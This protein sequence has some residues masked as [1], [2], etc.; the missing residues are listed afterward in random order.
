MKKIL[1]IAAAAT[2]LMTSCQKTDVLNVAEDTIDF[3]TQVGKLTKAN[4]EYDPLGTLKGQGFRVWTVAHFTQGQWKDGQIYRGMENLYVRYDSDYTTNPWIINSN[5][6]YFWPQ[7]QQYLQF[8]TISSNVMKPNSTDEYWVDDVRYSDH[9]TKPDGATEITG[10]DLPEYTVNDVADDDVMVADV[11]R[12]TKDDGSGN[13]TKTVSP[14]FRHTMTKV[15]FKFKKGTP[16]QNAAP[17]A[18]TVILKEIKTSALSYKGSLD[19]TYGAG[20]TEMSFEWTPSTGEGTTKV[21]SYT[22]STVVYL[23][24]KGKEIPVVDD[25][26]TEELAENQYCKIGD[27][28]YAYTKETEDATQLT[29]NVTTDY[30]TYNGDVLSADDFESYVTW[31]MIPQDLDE[32]QTVEITYIADGK[33]IP[34]IFKLTVNHSTDLTKD[35]TEEM[36]V[37]YNVT[38]TPQKVFFN[39]EVKPWDTD[40]DDDGTDDTDVDMEN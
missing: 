31:Y 28:V 17:V 4:D 35:W 21:F 9:F 6:R 32:E 15:E 27:T 26:P 37:K 3:S 20:T 34:Q 19:V 38:I 29:W 25:Y 11:K 14:Y 5:E 7:A 18:S 12:Q 8:Y 13:K 22:P 40:Q 36:W 30:E 39:P 24:P 23:D 1:Y 33:V 16:S 10:L 2:L